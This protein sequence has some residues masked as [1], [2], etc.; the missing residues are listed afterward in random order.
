MSE[1]LHPNFLREIDLHEAQLF[2]GIFFFSFFYILES[3][4]LV[5]VYYGLLD[6]PTLQLR[7]TPFNRLPG[8]FLMGFW[9]ICICPSPDG[10]CRRRFLELSLRKCSVVKKKVAKSVDDRQMIDALLLIR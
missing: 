4:S 10:H 7:S 6:D 3:S 5:D 2:P 9:D 8:Q 1:K